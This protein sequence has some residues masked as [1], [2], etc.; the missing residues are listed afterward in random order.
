MPNGT[1]VRKVMEKLF[2]LGSFQRIAVK[3]VINFIFRS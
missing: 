3:K 2:P 1:W